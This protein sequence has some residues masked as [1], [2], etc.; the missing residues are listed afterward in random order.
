MPK[1]STVKWALGGDEPEDLQDFLSNEDIERKNGGLP[2]KGTYKFA[3]RQIR[4]GAIKSGDNK[5]KP[6]LSIMLT[7]AEPKGSPKAKWNGYMI[8]DGL[9]I[10]DGPNL[11]F[12]KR[13]MR[14]LGLTW[15]DF[16]KRTKA[17]D[18][19]PPHITQIGKVKFESGKDPVVRASISVKGPDDYNDGDH[20]EIGRYLPA[21]DDEPVESDEDA[22]EDEDEE[23]G[24]TLDVDDEDDEDEDEEDEDDE[25][26]EDEEDESVAELREEL[27]GMKV[28]A[29][30]KRAVA[31]GEDDDD[32]EEMGKSELVDLII[33][34]ETEDEDEDEDDEPDE[35]AIEEMRGELSGLK[36]AALK[37]RAL[38]ND[39]D[40]D[41][42][43]MKKADLVQLILEQELNAPPF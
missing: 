6:R 27:Q 21:D 11:S 36:V 3:V 2:T 29:L 26:E 39:K 42:D 25:D 1:Q 20:V 35:D 34:Q 38:R 37:K 9:N 30:R 4:K 18:Q 24:I 15:D 22:D 13:F 31:N 28:K 40:A 32:V 43:G 14:A 17:D 7:V 41:L 23:D 8:W 19:D 5:D 33:E 10:I 16:L 12:V